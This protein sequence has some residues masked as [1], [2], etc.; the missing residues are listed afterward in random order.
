MRQDSSFVRRPSTSLWTRQDHSSP[1]SRKRKGTFL[2]VHPSLSPQPRRTQLTGTP[3]S[4]NPHSNQSRFP[5]LST[6]R[7]R[8]SRRP[9]CRRHL[10][11]SFS[12]RHRRRRI[13]RP[14]RFRAHGLCIH[15]QRRSCSTNILTSRIFDIGWKCVHS[16][17][18]SG[19][20]CRGGR[21]GEHEGRCG[22]FQLQ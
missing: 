16:C 21:S 4:R 11:C 8:R 3:G 13:R 1:D 5:R 9:P 7:K 2:H 14:N 22:D 6:L 17:W 12:N 19:T 15:P 20:E 10:V 18:T